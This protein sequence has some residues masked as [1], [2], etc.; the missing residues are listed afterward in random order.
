MIAIFIIMP[1]H[2]LVFGVSG[3]ICYSTIK[4]LT[5]WVNWNPQ[6]VNFNDIIHECQKCFFF[7]YFIS[8]TLSSKVYLVK[9]VVYIDAT[10]LENN[11][12]TT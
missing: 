2:Q 10:F 5:S 1:K 12:G 11:M 4:D 6:L 8:A 3:K 9:F 7:F